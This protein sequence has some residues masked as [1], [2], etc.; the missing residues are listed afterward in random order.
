MFVIPKKDS[1]MCPVT[2]EMFREPVTGQDGHTYERGAIISWLKKY[3]TSPITRESMTIDS[4]QPNHHVKQ[5]VGE[6][7]TSSLQ[8]RFLFKFDIDIQKAE[9]KPICQSPG[10]TIHRAEWISKPGPAVV[11]CAIEGA[12]ASLE[13]SCYVELSS[14]PHIVHTYGLAENDFN[15]LM[16]I[17]E[18]ATKGDLAEA[19]KENEFQPS[20]L[21]L[22]EIFLQIVDAMVYLANYGIVHGDLACRNVFVFRFHNSNPQEN[23]VKLSDFGLIRSSTLY[24]VVGST[25]STANLLVTAR[26]AAPEILQIEGFSNYSEKSDVYSMGILMWEAYSQGQSPY[27]SI[28]DDNDVRRLKLNEDIFSRPE[29]CDE[30]LW[31]IIVQCWHQQPE[32]RPTFKMLKQSLLEL[33]LQSIISSNG[34]Q[35]KNMENKTTLEKLNLNWREL[36]EEEVQHV[37]KI[38]T[39]NRTLTQLKLVDNDIT[40]KGARCLARALRINQTLKEIDLRYNRIGDLGAQYFA[41]V[42]RKDE[43]I[44]HNIISLNINSNI[45]EDQK[46]NHLLKQFSQYDSTKLANVMRTNQNLKRLSLCWNKIGPQGAMHLAAALKQNQTLTTLDLGG[47][48]IGDVGATYIAEALWTNK[49]IFFNILEIRAIH[50]FR[51]FAQTLTT[52]DLWGNAIGDAG[53]KYLAEA[54]RNNEILTTL[55]LCGNVI[56][57]VG[58]KYLVE[59]LSMRSIKTLAVKSF[60]N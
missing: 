44:K 59:A 29:N 35:N 26:Y 51:H 39:N 3:R 33:K 55:D 23:L 18:Y 37:A 15:R 13:A 20:Q 7:K 6:F 42:L 14:H 1:L 22:L 10:K 54:L 49:V 53:A 30:K 48:A 24:S 11:L 17:Q 2:C 34:V 40:H 8:K 25:V 9:G 28:E 52:L 4:L 16:L 47:N 43:V 46:L 57:D 21:V 27:T 19:L 60:T 56:G 38:L 5:L 50:L 45:Q 31:N 58:A 12:T 36:C 32:V 41:E